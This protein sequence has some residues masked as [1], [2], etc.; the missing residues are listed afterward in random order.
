MFALFQLFVLS[1]YLSLA[2][3]SKVGVG[4]AILWSSVESAVGIIAG[5]LPSL[6]KLFG[7]HFDTKGDSYRR[8]NSGARAGAQNTIGGTPFS[9]VRSRTHHTH[10]QLDS[11]GA[12]GKPKGSNTAFVSSKD[13]GR[14]GWDQLDDDDDGES[15]IRGIA[16][17]TSIHV[18]VK[19]LSERESRKSSRSA[20]KGR[21]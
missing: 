11:L 19:S 13:R 10:H 2:N 1:H 16:M 9:A 7:Y 6:R 17:N 12:D 4:Y 21:D 18:E 15:S 5:S 14:G 8:D 3:I 20:W